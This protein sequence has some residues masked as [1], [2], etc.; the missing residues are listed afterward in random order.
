MQW[1]KVLRND[2]S[3]DQHGVK[4]SADQPRV[5]TDFEIDP[6]S[7]QL[8]IFWIVGASAESEKVRTLRCVYQSG[9]WARVSYEWGEP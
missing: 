4:V 8:S 2:G 3:M 5:E 6:S 9:A 7:G 1:V